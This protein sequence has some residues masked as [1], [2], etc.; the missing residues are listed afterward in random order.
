MALAKAKKSSGSHRK[1][2]PE[3]IESKSLAA[4]PWLIHG[5]S[6]RRGGRSKNYGGNALNLG[7][8][9]EDS[10]EVVQLNRKLF[11][12]NLAGGAAAKWRTETLRQIHSSVIHRI[13]SPRAGK[14]LSK[15]NRAG[16]IP[17]GDG[18]ITN[19]PGI[20]MGIKTADC[21]PVLLVD[22]TR[23]AA[24]AF[25][26]GWRGTLERI[27]EK[28]VGE[29]RRCFGTGPKDIVAVIGPGIHRCCYI[30]GE[31]LRDKFESQFAYAAQLFEEKANDDEIHRKYP[32][33]FMNMRAPGHG[34]PE[35]AVH[36]D[37]AEANRQQLLAAG[38]PARNIE[39]S[40]LCTSCRTD[41]LFSHRAE[42]GKTGRMMA[43]VGLRE[44]SRSS[45]KKT[46]VKQRVE[47]SAKTA[48]KRKASRSKMTGS[49][50][51][52]KD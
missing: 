27:V 31:E 4:I 36:L 18:L 5:F 25:H 2:I 14:P 26:A 6:T 42:R 45:Q 30:V 38:V 7:Q 44:A 20:L 16:I 1:S 41:L 28:G 23:R 10:Q 9:T 48:G 21:L 12:S 43:V 17:A 22:T 3:I 50:V 24:G 35:V 39:V 15:K 46:R 49:K 11:L 47:F 40:G 32:L 33:L 8:T 52:K 13:G 51:R 37:L 29:M 19:Q 34:E